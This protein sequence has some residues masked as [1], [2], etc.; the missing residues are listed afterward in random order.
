[1]FVVASCLL[2]W[3]L[4][5]V[6]CLFVLFVGRCLLLVVVSWLMVICHC[7]LLVVGCKF[8]F[9]VLFVGCWSVVC[10]GLLGVVDCLSVD[11]CFVRVVVC[12]LLYGVLYS[13]LHGVG[14]LLLVVGLVLLVVHV[15]GCCCSCVAYGVLQVPFLVAVCILFGVCCF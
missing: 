10:F 7:V 13:L 11:I 14:N 1:M 4:F 15:A 3:L 5:V 6:C 12:C 9:C 2:V 8:L